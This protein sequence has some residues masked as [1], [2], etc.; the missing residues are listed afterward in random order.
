M[1]VK[2]AGG[3][4]GFEQIDTSSSKAVVKKAEESRMS[5]VDARPESEETWQL[6]T[7]T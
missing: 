4:I 5:L 3:E 1:E 2:D 7:Q 6:R